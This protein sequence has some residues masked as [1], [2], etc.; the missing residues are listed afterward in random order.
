MAFNVRP[1]EINGFIGNFQLKFLDEIIK[2]RY[3][4]LLFINEA[5]KGNIT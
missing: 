1:S 2:K 5:I 3:K 4:N